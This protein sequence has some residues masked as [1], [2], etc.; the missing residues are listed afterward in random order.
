MASLAFP[1]L[2]DA[3][4][5]GGSEAARVPAHSHT[6]TTLMLA[7][8]TRP[9][10]MKVLAGSSPQ[11]NCSS[12]VVKASPGAKVR[13]SKVSLSFV[14]HRG[15]RI[16]MGGA[17][18]DVGVQLKAVIALAEHFTPFGP[19]RGPGR[20]RPQIQEGLCVLES[21]TPVIPKQGGE[22]PKCS[23]LAFSLWPYGQTDH[24]LGDP[25][26]TRIQ[27]PVTG[28]NCIDTC[29]AGIAQWPPS[30]LLGWSCTWLE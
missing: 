12:P 14:G 9:L 26:G 23:F 29:P 8:E 19:G 6:T 25:R 20:G 2:P 16:Q 11:S 21:F 15:N 18:H 10:I 27:D 28:I 1:V 22:R 30:C 24:V 4:L 5:N 13:A 3:Q 17:V 7:E